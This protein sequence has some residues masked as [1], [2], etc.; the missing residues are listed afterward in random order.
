MRWPLRI[1]AIRLGPHPE[2]WR[3]FVLLVVML[4]TTLVLQACATMPAVV[5]VEEG[6]SARP[7]ELKTGQLLEIRLLERGRGTKIA[8]GSVVTPT[9]ALVGQP[10]F[11]DDPARDGVSGTGNYQAWLFRAVQPGSVDVRMD[12]RLQWETIGAPSRSVTFKVA[13]Q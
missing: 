7:L 12:Y 4:A 11:H 6:D 5:R 9:L 13:V 3:P 1:A 8:L 10:A 2:W